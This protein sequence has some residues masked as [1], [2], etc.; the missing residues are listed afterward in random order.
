MENA[1]LTSLRHDASIMLYDL[2]EK[3][4]LTVVQLLRDL[5]GKKDDAPLRAP[6]GAPGIAA[7]KFVLPDDFD[8]DNELIAD[9]FEGK[10]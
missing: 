4:L 10:Q 7:G 5:T 9:L 2:P 6:R 3:T 8:A 1:S